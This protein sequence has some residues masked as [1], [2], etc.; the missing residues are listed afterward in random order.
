MIL[1]LLAVS[2][3][4][5]PSPMSVLFLRSKVVVI[6]AAPSQGRRAAV[7]Q[8]IVSGGIDTSA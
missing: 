1:S 8:S 5:A 6:L 2:K 7:G 3:P 4:K